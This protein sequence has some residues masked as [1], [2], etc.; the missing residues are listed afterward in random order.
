MA[1]RRDRSWQRFSMVHNRASR[2][3]REYFNHFCVD[4]GAHRSEPEFDDVM[5]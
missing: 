1:G 5:W 2:F 3:M 4:R